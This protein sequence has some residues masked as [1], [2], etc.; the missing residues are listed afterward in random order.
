MDKDAEALVE[1]MNRI[2]KEKEVEMKG[3]LKEIERLK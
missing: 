1:A 3:H 2:E